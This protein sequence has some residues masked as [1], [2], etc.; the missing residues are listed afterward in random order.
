MVILN[1]INKNTE[2]EDSKTIEGVSVGLEKDNIFH[3]TVGFG[4]PSD[5]AYEVL[6]KFSLNN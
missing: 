4:G 6:L 1:N 2:L 3:W 5:T